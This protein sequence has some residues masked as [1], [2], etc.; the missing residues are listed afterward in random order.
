MLTLGSDDTGAP[1]WQTVGEVSIMSRTIL[2]LGLFLPITASAQ[3]IVEA[4]MGAGRATTM[5]APAR[6]LGKSMSG[7]AGGLEKALNGGEA[8]KKTVAVKPTPTSEAPP[9]ITIREDADGIEEG[10][11]YDELI[12]RF[13]KPAMSITMTGEQSLTYKGIAGMYRVTVR[14]GKVTTVEPPAAAR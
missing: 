10:I 3:A 7:I 2:L 11:A 9:A 1:S 8:E 13:G 5:A 12:Q 6:G 14:G 4:A